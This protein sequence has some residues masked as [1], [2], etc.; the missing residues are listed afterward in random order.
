M[1]DRLMR[2]AYEIVFGKCETKR[3][4]KRPSPKLENKVKVGLREIG[5]VDVD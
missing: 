3:P 5:C 2:N 1:S 4:F